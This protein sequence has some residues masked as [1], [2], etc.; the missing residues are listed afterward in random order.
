MTNGENLLISMEFST[1]KWI[2]FNESEFNY[3]KT[4]FELV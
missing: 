1:V 3:Q 4:Q 2:S